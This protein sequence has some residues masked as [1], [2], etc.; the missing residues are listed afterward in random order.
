MDLPYAKTVQ[1]VL[2]RLNA[3]AESEVSQEIAESD[4][5]HAAGDPAHYFAVGQSAINAIAQGMLLSGMTDPRTVLD[6]ACGHGRVLR[7]MRVFFPDARLVACDILRSGVDH[8]TETFG[9]E[10]VYASEDF[11][12]V[13]F[14]CSFDV[15]WCGSLLTHLPEKRFGDCL[16]LLIDSLSNGGV[17]VATT[18]G[19]FA[20]WVQENLGM[21]MSD[22]RFAPAERGFSES[23][24]GFAKYP[25]AD[26]FGIALSSPSSTLG[27]IAKRPNVRILGYQER[28]WDDQQDVFILARSSID[29]APGTAPYPSSLTARDATG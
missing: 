23:G 3:Y 28:G 17:L 2:R 26:D 24:F 11:A 27:M 9:V 4:E 15:V 22:E 25:G 19:R 1:E 12:E 8:C 21:Y 20:I 6:M 13:R 7:H 29:T 18:V 16:T 10:G 14:G 5:M